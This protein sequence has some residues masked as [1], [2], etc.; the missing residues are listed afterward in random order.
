MR[1]PKL[2]LIAA[3]GAI[4][5]PSGAQARTANPCA[6]LTG[7]DLAPG[8]GQRAVLRGSTLQFCAR[9][10]AVR[11]LG[12][13]PAVRAADERL[14][15]LHRRGTAEVLDVGTGRRATLGPV[16]E[17]V[18][19]HVVNRAGVAAVR[20]TATGDTV[21]VVA[22]G[23]ADVVVQRGTGLVE[24]PKADAKLAW[25]RAGRTRVALLPHRALRCA[26]LRGEDE[27]I[28]PGRVVNRSRQR[29]VG[30]TGAPDAP[31]FV[32]G[33]QF[34]GEMDSSSVSFTAG[35]GSWLL[36]DTRASG[37]VSL[38]VSWDIV[39]LAT[40]RV[41]AVAHHRSGF[42]CVP[43]GHEVRAHVLLADGRLA[44]IQDAHEGERGSV[45]VV[46][47][48]GQER[49]EL[50][51]TELGAPKAMDLQVDGDL[52]RWTVGGEPRSALLSGIS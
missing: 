42:C 51:R 8:A 18:A 50:G 43:S 31:T 39:D 5:L 22:P 3:L 36:R 48:P 9:G 21:L 28:G 4:L 38:D 6:A 52:V 44:S 2:L 13:A 23:R 25:T 19:A 33:T 17:I 32:V 29:F 26:D 40:G 41:Q 1:L 45:V 35:R 16:D 14:L 20:R 47:L 46:D 30:C 27:L 24:G 49:V 10:G 11:R 12:G 15:L 34:E 7:R 37:K